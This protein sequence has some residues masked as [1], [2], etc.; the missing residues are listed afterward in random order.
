MYHVSIPIYLRVVDSFSVAQYTPVASSTQ[1]LAPLPPTPIFSGALD[2]PTSDVLPILTLSQVLQILSLYSVLQ[3]LSASGSPTSSGTSV[4]PNFRDAWDN[5]TSSGTSASPYTSEM[6][7]IIP[8][9][10]VLQP[11][12]TSEVL[13]IIQ[14]S[15]VLPVRNSHFLTYKYSTYWYARYSDDSVNNAQSPL[16]LHIL[17]PTQL[18]LVLSLIW[19]LR[20]SRLLS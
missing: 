10:P 13:E 3:A 9:T 4:S 12:P 20:D 6:L 14:P 19:Y 2:V 15:P 18:M 7:E 8:P 1:W 17:P 11:A 16:F 5:S